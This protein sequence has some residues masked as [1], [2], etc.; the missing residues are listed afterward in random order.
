[1][2]RK[3]YLLISEEEKKKIKKYTERWEDYI[4]G[5]ACREYIISEIHNGGGKNFLGCAF[6]KN[7]HYLIVS[8]TLFPHILKTHERNF[9]LMD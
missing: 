6:E 4:K 3:I 8:K 1:M 5:S 7:N 9:C 2:F